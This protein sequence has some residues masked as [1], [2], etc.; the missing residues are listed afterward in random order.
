MG[1]YNQRTELSPKEW[2]CWD[3]G[4]Y[5]GME[6]NQEW[7][8]MYAGKKNATWR[9]NLD[10]SSKHKPPGTPLAKLIEMIHLSLTPLL[11]IIVTATVF[12]GDQVD[13]QIQP[14][15]MPEFLLTDRLWHKSNSAALETVKKRVEET[16]P[17]TS[18]EFCSPNCKGRQVT[19]PWKV[20]HLFQIS[21]YF[22]K[23]WGF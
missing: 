18:L 22:E 17:K 2:H 11:L 19:A 16:Y 21:K 23:L 13:T 20:T 9:T 1:L 12:S 5:N 15:T 6:A 14:C 7:R 3:W 4:Q 10:H 8:T